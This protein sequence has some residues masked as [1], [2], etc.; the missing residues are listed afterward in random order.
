MPLVGCHRERSCQDGSSAGGPWSS[1]DGPGSSTDGQWFPKGRLRMARGRLRM[2]SGSQ[3]GRLRM[4]RGRLRMARGSS[5]DGPGV[6]YGWPV[7][8][9]GW[10]MVLKGVVYGWPVVVYGWPMVLKGVV[11]GWPM[12]VCEW[13]VVPKWAVYGRPMVSSADDQ[14][15]PNGSSTDGPWFQKQEQVCGSSR[16]ERVEVPQLQSVN[17]AVVFQLG[18]RGK[19]PWCELGRK[20]WRLHAPMFVTAL[21]LESPVVVEQVIRSRGRVRGARTRGHVCTRSLPSRQTSPRFCCIPPA[22]SPLHEVRVS[23]MVFWP[24]VTELT[25]ARTVG[26]SRNRVKVL[27]ESRIH[28]TPAARVCGRMVYPCWTTIV[29][30]RRGLPASYGLRSGPRIRAVSSD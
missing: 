17:S 18:S 9:Y 20:P 21:V 3:K 5:T 29:P 22:C 26:R 30:L 1:T 16:A 4:A 11:Y 24:S 6:V 2:S 23:T 8:V 12:V 15:F 28:Q 13:P 25:L 14:W 27:G 7:V 10:P 19:Y